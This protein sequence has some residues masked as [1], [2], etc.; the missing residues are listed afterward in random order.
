MKLY[1]LDAVQALPATPDEAWRF[2]S[3]PRNLAFITPPWLRFRLLAD[4]PDEAY[5]GMIIP[6]TIQ[7]FPGV[8]VT[9]VT[10]ITHLEPP[11][12]FV[13]EQRLGPYAFWHHQ[14]RLRPVPGGVEVADVVHYALPF[15]PVG[16]DVH[17]AAVGR[18]L[19]DIFAFRRRTLERIFRPP[20]PRPER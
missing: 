14:H 18:Q 11:R 7:P 19:R 2:F 6:Y 9:W 3:D 16:R 8:P 1:R 4:L 17:A 10:E 5:A 12:F 20:S 13:D 15:G